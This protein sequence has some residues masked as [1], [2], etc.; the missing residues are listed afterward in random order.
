MFINK[1]TVI[2]L[3]PFIF[4]VILFIYLENWAR[5]DF[6]ELNILES[7]YEYVHNNIEKIENLFL[8]NCDSFYAFN[9]ISYPGEG[10][11]FSYYYTSANVSYAFLKNNIKKAKKLKNVILGISI[12]TSGFDTSN[13]LEAANINYFYRKKNLLKKKFIWNEITSFWLESKFLSNSEYILSVFFGGEKTKLKLVSNQSDKTSDRAFD[14]VLRNGYLLSYKDDS[15]IKEDDL[16]YIKN[17]YLPRLNV[18]EKTIKNIHDIHKLAIHNDITFTLVVLPIVPSS[19][20]YIKKV[21]PE[22]VTKF[23]KMI[24]SLNKEMNVVII[25]Q[26]LAGH[27]FDDIEQLNIKGESIVS[28]ELRRKVFHVLP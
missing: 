3:V 10:Y 5:N 26:G 14:Y 9:P 21:S 12:V 24:E 25:K 11:N 16:G 13:L 20:K 23:N 17:F 4:I 22:I 15:L 19:Y 1:I 7:K 6:E 2:F 8:G 27:F 18:Y 28:E